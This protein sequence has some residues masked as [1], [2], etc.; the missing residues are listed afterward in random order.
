MKYVADGSIGK[1]KVRFVARGFSQKEGVKYKE[2]FSL[3]MRWKCKC[4]EPAQNRSSYKITQ[5]FAE[6][7]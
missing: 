2:M 7:N 6:R 5:T 3:V 1:F 4:V